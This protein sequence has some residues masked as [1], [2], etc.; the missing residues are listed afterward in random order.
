VCSRT[1]LPS[2]RELA[3]SLVQF[4]SGGK[5]ER[6]VGYPLSSFLI[7]RCSPRGGFPFVFFVLQQRPGGKSEFFGSGFGPR[8]LS[9]CV[10]LLFFTRWRH[11]QPQISVPDRLSLHP[12]LESNV[13][14]P[15][16]HLLCAR[17]VQ[18]VCPPVDLATFACTA[19]AVRQLLY[20]LPKHRAGCDCKR[21]GH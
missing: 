18:D 14:G 12:A 16:G 7:Q 20:L 9:R 17:L 8:D 15:L 10:G 3:D 13:S 11:L 19:P 1:A 2:G 21:A 5:F 4:R 6:S